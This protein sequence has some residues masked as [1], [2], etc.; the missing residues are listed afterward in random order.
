MDSLKKCVV[1]L[2]LVLA[3]VPAFA[4]DL[5]SVSTH[6][7]QPTVSP[8]GANHGD[9]LITNNTTSDVR[10]R[11]DVRVVYADGTV[12]RLTGLTYSGTLGPGEGFAQ[13]IFFVIPPDAAP[14]PAT[15]TASVSASSGGLQEQETS[16]ATFTVL[17][18]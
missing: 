14:G 1:V 11:M 17:I 9:I 10:F 16:S 12:Q 4:A 18:L 6:V 3:A 13:S 5:V 2:M 7:S 15:F 8:G